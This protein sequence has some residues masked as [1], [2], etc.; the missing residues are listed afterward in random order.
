MMKT[1][2]LYVILS[3]IIL[4]FPAF[5]ENKNIEQQLKDANKLYSESKFE[6]AAK[7]YEALISENYVSPELFFN[8]GNTYYRL[9]EIGKAIY[10]YEKAKMLAP[11]D[12]DI[13]YNLDL[14][15]LR[16][17]NL[18]PEVPKIFPVRV[19]KQTVFWKS[20]AFWGYVSLLLFIVFLIFVWFY[21]VSET[22][23]AKKIRLPA[24]IIFLFFSITAFIFMQYNK[25]VLTAHNEAIIINNEIIAKSSPEEKANDLFKVY[26]GYK[27]KIEGNSGD[28]Y[29]IKLSDGRK[30][31][32]KKDA[33]MV[34]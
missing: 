9:N 15:K 22:S 1:K 19:F 25:S 11:N 24:A 20:Y 29:E 10:Y 26:E 18:P 16:V 21:F 33:L 3:I 34:L 31:W 4:N 14:A 30:A 13:N 27:V 32:V 5:S 2:I 8:A 17:K 6:E 23:K 12:D 7:Q 28:W